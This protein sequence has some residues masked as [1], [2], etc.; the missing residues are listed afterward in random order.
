MIVLQS[1]ASGLVPQGQLK[2]AGV[3][4]ACFSAGLIIQKYISPAGTAESVFSLCHPKPDET[5]INR[6]PVKKQTENKPKTNRDKPK[7]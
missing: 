1:W 3:T 6:A 5:Q 2:I 7:N 4:R